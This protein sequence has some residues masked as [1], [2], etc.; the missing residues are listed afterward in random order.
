MVYL[1]YI[2]GT[3][4]QS[5]CQ[6]V[7]LKAEDEQVSFHDILRLSRKM[8]ADLPENKTRWPDINGNNNDIELQ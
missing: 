4:K 8:Q 6:G 1:L 2:S 5:H 7:K 3:R